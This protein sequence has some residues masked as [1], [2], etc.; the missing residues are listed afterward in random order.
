MKLFKQNKCKQHSILLVED[1]S[2]CRLL[3]SSILKGNN[4]IVFEA[5]NGKDALSIYKKHAPDLLLTDVNMPEMNGIELIK[6]IR[7]SNLH[8][9]IIVMSVE[10][11][12][13]RMG[14]EAGANMTFLKMIA[15]PVLLN[16]IGSLL[17]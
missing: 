2:T 9:P 6:N 13:L 17:L 8:L 11:Q 1:D 15:V 10:Q 12:S 7:E 3:M 5:V 14:E 4:Y 16:M